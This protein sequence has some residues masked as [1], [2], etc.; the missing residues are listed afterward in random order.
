[1]NTSTLP[2]W[3]V[4]WHQLSSFVVVW[5]CHIPEV[6]IV[7]TKRVAE[8]VSEKFQR[9]FSRFRS[10]VRFWCSRRLLLPEVQIFFWKQIV[11]HR[12]ILP[13]TA[14]ANPSYG[15]R[16]VIVVTC[17][18][19]TKARPIHNLAKSRQRHVPQYLISG[20][21]IDVDNKMACSWYYKQSAVGASCTVMLVFGLRR[22]L[23][24][25]RDILQ[26]VRYRRKPRDTKA[27][28]L[29]RAWRVDSIASLPF[30]PT[31]FTWRRLPQPVCW[32]Y[33]LSTGD[34][35]CTKAKKYSRQVDC[36]TRIVFKVTYYV[37]SGT[38]R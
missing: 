5:H 9:L 25:N 15:S 29:Y 8:E 2:G 23:V 13:S 33:S 20:Y 12:F 24:T 16:S 26:C 7:A 17:R 10:G 18:T 30:Q 28:I 32:L 38:G 22:R 34:S 4:E 14:S 6:D 19:S 1:M 36:V 31:A 27:S 11:K 3:P 21:A 35:F 37:S